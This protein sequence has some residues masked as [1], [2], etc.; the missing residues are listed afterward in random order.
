[1]R[2]EKLHVPATGICL[3]SMYFPY[4]SAGGKK[5]LGEK[6]HVQRY[7][8]CLH[9]VQLQECQ[10]GAAS[11]RA[12]WG[13]RLVMAVLFPVRQLGLAGRALR[14]VLS[15]A[16]AAVWLLVPEL[17]QV[18]PQRTSV[19]LLGYSQTAWM[20]VK[21]CVPLRVCASNVLLMNCRWSNGSQ[22]HL[23]IQPD[24]S[25]FVS[26]VC[27]LSLS[28]GLLMTTRDIYGALILHCCTW[29]PVIFSGLKC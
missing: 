14:L 4:C 11:A 10:H 13:R 3:L 18:C 9:T 8:S 7:S 5:G 25:E 24:F 23:R 21:V 20:F 6:T 29:Q 28:R 22:Q 17:A 12:D 15:S 16:A 27:S 2:T 1:M 19:M 26:E